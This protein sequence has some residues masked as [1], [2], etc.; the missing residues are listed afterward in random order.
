MNVPR[1]LV[2]ATSGGGGK[3]LVAVGLARAWTR[4]GI[5]V[6]P[7]KKGPDYIDAEWLTRA[8]GVPCRNLDLF[9]MP[10]GAAAQSFVGAAHSADV[11]VVEGNRGLYDGSDGKG[12]YSSAELAKLLSV[13]VLLVVDGTKTTRTAAAIVLGCQRLDSDVEIGGVILNRVAGKRHESVLREAIEAECGVPV[14]GSIPRLDPAPFPER[15]LGLVPPEE[16][17]GFDDAVEKAADIIEAHLDL[18][19]IRDVA[20]RARPIDVPERPV[21]SVVVVRPEGKP[22]IGIFRDAAFQFYYAENLEALEREG[23]ELVEISPLRD[24]GLPDVDALYIGGGFPETLAEGLARNTAF[25][26]ALR[27]CVEDGLPIYAECGGAVYLG[28]ELHMDGTVYPM[29]GAVPAVYGFGVRP[30]GHGYA[31]LESVQPNPFFDVGDTFRGHEFHYTY[32]ES[33][34]TDRVTFAF[35]VRRG[36]GFDGEHDGLCYRNVLAAYIHLHALGVESWA[37]S[38]VGAAVR[39]RQSL[40]ATEGSP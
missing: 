12:T 27:E 29:A 23:A 20:A 28:E 39:R 37:P 14:L 3:T 4:Q 11:A 30:N 9:L 6:A 36:H 34:D 8:T 35:R 38:L 40:A 21:R 5:V 7:F 33:A 17:V 31:V 32:L 22:R 15:H 10:A 2:S 16:H 1:V 13:P 19:R 26:A 25:R 18:E 24:T